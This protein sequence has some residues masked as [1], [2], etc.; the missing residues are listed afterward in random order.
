MPN[1]EAKFA[2]P[3]PALSSLQYFAAFLKSAGAGSAAKAA[4]GAITAAESAAATSSFFMDVLLEV[5]D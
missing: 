1:I 4:A 2:A 5:M 3:E